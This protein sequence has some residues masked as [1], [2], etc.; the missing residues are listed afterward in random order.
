M[1]AELKAGAS[2]LEV[3]KKYAYE[4]MLNK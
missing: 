2:I 4:Q 1:V 3:D